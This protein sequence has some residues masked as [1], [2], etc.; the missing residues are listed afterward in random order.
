M[1]PEASWYLDTRSGAGEAGEGLVGG[2]GDEVRR[3]CPFAEQRHVGPQ[4]DPVL[5][6][7]ATA[8]GLPGR[9]PDMDH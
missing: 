9:G 6:G 2:G 8:Q 7:V 1:Q 3:C 5:A 4:P